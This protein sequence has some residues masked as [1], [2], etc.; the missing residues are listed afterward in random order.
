MGKRRA[1]HIEV[2]PS[3][4][5][6]HCPLH[7]SPPP[8]CPG[9]PLSVGRQ[10]PPHPRWGKCVPGLLVSCWEGAGGLSSPFSSSAPAF[11]LPTRS[12]PL[13]S[14]SASSLR[15]ARCSLLRSARSSHSG[16]LF[17]DP[18]SPTRVRAV[19]LPKRANP[20]PSLSHPLYRGARG[21]PRE[22]TQQIAERESAEPAASARRPPPRP[23]PVAQ[24]PALRARLSR[25]FR[26][27]SQD[28]GRRA[29]PLSVRF[30]S[31][32]PR[33]EAKRR[34][35]RPRTGLRAS[36]GEDWISADPNGPQP[37]RLRG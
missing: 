16:G 32:G 10:S 35:A 7:L 19:P 1:R 34:A 3:T 12:A 17:R 37:R 30:P 20:R 26:C 18:L 15:K 2:L 22:Q 4:R 11:S 5:R 13:A 31:R 27:S 6:A 23:A 36:S 24:T 33:Q 8:A 21:E 9:S 25:P 28:G 29:G 14:W